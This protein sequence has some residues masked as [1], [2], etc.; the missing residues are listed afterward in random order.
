MKTKLVV[1]FLLFTIVN[2]L[3]SCE[4]N[5]ETKT[6]E[7]VF[8]KFTDILNC[9]PIEVDVI[10]NSKSVGTI[11]EDFR[12]YDSIPFCGAEKCVTINYPIGSYSYKAECYCGISKTLM[13]YWVGT[14]EVK[15]DSCTKVFF[16]I[17]R[18]IEQ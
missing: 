16:D 3:Q 15:Q 14:L 9:G 17:E 2:S 11:H 4:K 1:Y 18:M 5:S 12:P 13:G 6:G 8:W 10:I 7:I